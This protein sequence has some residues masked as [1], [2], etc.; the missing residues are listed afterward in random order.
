[1]ARWTHRAGVGVVEKW[2]QRPL[3]DHPS[4]VDENVSNRCKLVRV[5]WARKLRRSLACNECESKE[6]IARKRFVSMFFLW[7]IK[8][9]ATNWNRNTTT[10]TQLKAR[11]IQWS[12][13]WNVRSWKIIKSST[14][15]ESI[16]ANEARSK[17]CLLS[18]ACS[19]KVMSCSAI[20]TD[21]VISTLALIARRL[22]DASQPPDGLLSRISCHKSV[23]MLMKARFEYLEHER[24]FDKAEIWTEI[25]TWLDFTFLI[26][27]ES[28]S[29]SFWAI[30]SE[31]KM[32][33]I[34]SLPKGHPTTPITLDSRNW[35]TL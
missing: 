4:W 19:R 25:R 29:R 31:I 26:V 8:H 6:N 32:N 23:Q 28:K 2:K 1:M 13:S 7:N 22:W 5:E 20:S 17:F 21:R 15:G 33:S 16:C 27:S 18:V 12:Q 14:P 24:S 9:V 3:V 11:V 10:T 30:N 34:P 35:G